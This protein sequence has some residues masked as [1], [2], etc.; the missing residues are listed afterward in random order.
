LWL[1]VLQ[2]ATGPAQCCKFAT[3][4]SALRDKNLARGIDPWSGHLESHIALN[5]ELGTTEDDD[6]G[7]TEY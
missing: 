4:S 3:V 1:P 5:P 2:A 6:E 7:D